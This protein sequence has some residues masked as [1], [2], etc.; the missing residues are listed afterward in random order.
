MNAITPNRLPATIYNINDYC[1]CIFTEEF[2]L[3]FTV[4][5]LALF[6]GPNSYQ[7]SHINV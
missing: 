2:K 5:F 4:Y 7:A 3:G 6:A 1:S